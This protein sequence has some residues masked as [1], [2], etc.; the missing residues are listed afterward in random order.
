MQLAGGA[1]SQH[2]APP[3]KVLAGAHL[4]HFC[5]CVRQVLGVLFCLGFGGSSG[6]LFLGLAPIGIFC[7]LEGLRSTK[8]LT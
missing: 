6:F 3:L 2:I 1:A 8:A 7:L 5:C 4:H